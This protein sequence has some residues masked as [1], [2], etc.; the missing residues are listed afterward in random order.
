VAILTPRAYILFVCVSV[1]VPSPA[2]VGELEE[3]EA[4]VRIGKFP[5]LPIMEQWKRDFAAACKKHD[6]RIRLVWQREVW[7]S[8]LVWL[9]ARWNESARAFVQELAWLIPERERDRIARAL[10]K[11]TEQKYRLRS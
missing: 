5:S 10:E 6:V 8:K 9:D 11:L 1:C 7:P 3:C 2:F 4:L